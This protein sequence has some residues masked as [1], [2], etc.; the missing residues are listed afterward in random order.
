MNSKS[1]ARERELIEL[2]DFYQA[3][4][5]KYL[6]FAKKAS[7]FN[8]WFENSE[9]DL[10]DPLRCNSVEEIKVTHFHV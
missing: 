10:R 5:D 8:S 9:E 6:L 2:R 7:N 1:S 3:I 4:E